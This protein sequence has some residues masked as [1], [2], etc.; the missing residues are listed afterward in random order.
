MRKC[1]LQSGALARHKT[2]ARTR[3]HRS[4]GKQ[5]RCRPIILSKNHPVKSQRPHRDHFAARMILPS[6]RR[7][8]KRGENHRLC[9]RGFL[10][11]YFG[12]N[13]FLSFQAPCSACIGLDSIRSKAL[14]LFL[15]LVILIPLLFLLLSFLTGK[16]PDGSVFGVSA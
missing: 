7:S 11:D 8:R 12:Q 10:Q 5:Q 9:G 3:S 15:I 2:V 14:G 6:T 1:C 16:L 13:N 4:G